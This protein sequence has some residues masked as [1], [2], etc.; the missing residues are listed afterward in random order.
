MQILNSVTTAYPTDQRLAPNVSGIG[1][2]DFIK[3]LWPDPPESPHS[4]GVG[5]LKSSTWAAL[6]SNVTQVI[7]YQLPATDLY[8]HVCAHDPKKTGSTGR[9]NKK[10]VTLMPA[11]WL[12]LDIHEKDPDKGYPPR[13]V[14]M[15]YL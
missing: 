9:G 4:F 1:V 15:D 13:K 3:A 8:F 11:I 5:S 6:N 12:D 2:A 10:S 14:A 7:E